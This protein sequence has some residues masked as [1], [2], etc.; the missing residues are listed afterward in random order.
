M[1]I[2]LGATGSGSGA[3]VV[4]MRTSVITVALA[5]TTIVSLAAAATAIAQDSS[6][7]EV[8]AAHTELLGR[9]ILPAETYRPGTAASGFFQTGVT[10]IPRPYPGQAVQGFSATHRNA[11]G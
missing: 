9:S 3:S 6:G 11:D 7:P 8:R 2:R 10:A 1:F 5:T 4:G